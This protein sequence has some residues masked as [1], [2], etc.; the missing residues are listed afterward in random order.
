MSIDYVS[1]DD[2]VIYGLITKIKNNCHDKPCSNINYR[3]DT[4]INNNN[5]HIRTALTAIMKTQQV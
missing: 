5:V 2:I 4:R 1:I 3:I